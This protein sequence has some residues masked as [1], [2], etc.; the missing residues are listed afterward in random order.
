M[1][2]HELIIAPHPPYSKDLAPSDLFLFAYLKRTLQRS[3]FD[4]PE[5]FRDAAVKITSAISPE[6]LLAT[7]HHQIDKP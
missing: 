6:T 3:E 2:V 4:S 1:E 7:F 5:E